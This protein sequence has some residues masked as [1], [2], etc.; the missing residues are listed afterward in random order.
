M[1]NLDYEIENLKKEKKKIYLEVE[2]IRLGINSS[3]APDK[4]EK[5]LHDHEIYLPLR[6]GKKIIS[7]KLPPV[8]VKE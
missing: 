4:I 1:A 6:T 2:S 3:S 5:L 7:V 8:D